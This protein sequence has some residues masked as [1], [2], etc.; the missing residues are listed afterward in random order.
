MALEEIVT[1]DCQSVLLSRQALSSVSSEELEDRVY[2]QN[3]NSAVT[4][5]KMQTT[6][7]DSAAM[8]QT[9]KTEDVAACAEQ[10]ETENAE[11]DSRVMAI[12]STKQSELDVHVEQSS[13]AYKG[14]KCMIINT[15]RTDLGPVIAVGIVDYCI[16]LIE[17]LIEV[18]TFANIV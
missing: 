11:A 3:V 16:S 9:A 1:R 14:N 15:N 10:N 4:T 18:M 12:E 13:G 6:T 2:E 17:S 7:L 5:L 8:L